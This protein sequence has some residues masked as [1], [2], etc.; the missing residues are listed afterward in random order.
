[1][2]EIEKNLLFIRKR[3]SRACYLRSRDD[4][5]IRLMLVTKTIP[6]EEIQLALQSNENL[7][8]ENK[9]QELKEKTDF[10]SKRDCEVH[11][12]GH[13]QTNKIK[14]VVH[15][16][17]CIQSVDRLSLAEK[18]DSYLQK[19]SR[20][21]DIL[22]QVNT[23]NETSK[24]GIS[25]EESISFIREVSKYDT[26][27]IKGLMTIGAFSQDSEKVRQCF[28]TLKNIQKKIIE[29]NIP[30]I[31]MKVM[32]MGMSN[33]LEIAIEEGSTMIRVGTAIFGSRTK[34]NDY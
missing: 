31:K 12:I 9:V 23:S 7:I 34:F 4:K 15:H 27:K 29:L 19:I 17:S 22:I 26:L 24:F 14:D 25:V 30:Q 1:M 3:I 2:S 21:I 6:T 20:S 28:K 8:G 32:S 5:K 16:V 13:L 33:D 11:F 18:L 10:F